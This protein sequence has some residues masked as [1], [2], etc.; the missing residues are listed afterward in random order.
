MLRQYRGITISVGLVCMFACSAAAQYSR[1]T[2]KGPNILLIT[3]DTLRAD[4]LGCYGYSAASTPVIDELAAQ[5][6]RFTQ[7][8]AQVPLTLPSHYSIL[9]GTYPFYHSVR[10]NSHGN[11]QGP[12][13]ISEFLRNAGY[14]T[15][16]FVGSALLDPRFGLNRGF[17]AYV[18]D[19][20]FSRSGGVDLSHIERPAGDV[21][22]SA[23]RWIASD[24]GKFFVWIHLFDPHDPY[25]PPEPFKTRFP[26]SPY[27]GEIAYVDQSIGI[28]VNS[29]KEEG[30][31]AHTDII[32]TSD[33]GE[34]LGAHGEF[35]H[36]FFVYEPTIHV[37]L[38]IRVASGTK[39]GK[40]IDDLVRSVD[41]APTILRLAGLPTAAE[42]QGKSLLGLLDDNAHSEARSAKAGDRPIYFETYYPL[43][44]FGWSELRGLRIGRH[45]YIDAPRPELYDLST[46]P[47]ERHNLYSSHTALAAHFKETL[48]SEVG[49]YAATRP[50]AAAA[51]PDPNTVELLRSLGYVGYVGGVKPPR[52]TSNGPRADPK[53]KVGVYADILH[54][55]NLATKGQSPA[56]TRILEGVLRENPEVTSARLV[57][58][59]QYQKMGRLSSAADEFAHALSNEPDNAL[60]AFNLAQVLEQQGK[61]DDALTL[62]HRALKIDPNFSPAHTALGVIYRK[63]RQRLEAIQEFERALEFGP[64]F[65]ARYNLAGIY[66]FSGQLDQALKNAQEAVN[67]QPTLPEAYNMLGSICYLRKEMPQAEHAF[68]K[69][70]ELSPR[71]DTA[72]TNLAEVYAQTGRVA[73]AKETL[74]RALSINPHQGA[75]SRL[76]AQLGE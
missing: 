75:A 28:L 68:L 13:V 10:D 34:G 6:Y 18:A 35:T 71:S 44:E 55:L 11:E 54:A 65:T 14:R 31:L 50:T 47:G 15:G 27:D 66:A 20:D 39:G 69:V 58:G 67:L 17:D 8:Y 5:G 48:R 25:S 29:L 19:F 45:K 46:D 21:V 76:L 41:I 24:T 42:M 56:A 60:C 62:Y 36:G 57:L 70:L 49:K 22:R 23:L 63:R 16:A 37:P 30:L 61:V 33:H 73:E 59:V 4:H 2:S 53:D 7:A 12:P 1:N 3:V 64:D 32:F 38:I 74:K 26:H 52:A 40:R 51:T 9:T 43:R 72:L